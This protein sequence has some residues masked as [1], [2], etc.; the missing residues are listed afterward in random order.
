MDNKGGPQAL[1]FYLPETK[2]LADTFGEMVLN[3]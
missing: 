3:V 1:L 2:V